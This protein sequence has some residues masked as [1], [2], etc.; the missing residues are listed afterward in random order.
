MAFVARVGSTE[1]AVARIEASDDIAGRVAGADMDAGSRLRRLPAV[2]KRGM[3]PMAAEAG[4]LL[5]PS[6]PVTPVRR[7]DN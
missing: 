6:A 5:V 2:E 3:V 4:E 7:E 1:G